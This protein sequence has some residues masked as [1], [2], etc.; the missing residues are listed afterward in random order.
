MARLFGESAVAGQ[1]PAGLTGQ[2]PSEGDTRQQQHQG[3][4]RYRERRNLQNLSSCASEKSGSKPVLLPLY[5]RPA[6]LQFH[7]GGIRVLLFSA[8]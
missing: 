2:G 3:E 1:R 7:Y 8:K 6:A 4:R 5:N